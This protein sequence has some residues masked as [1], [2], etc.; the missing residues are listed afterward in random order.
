VIAEG[1]IF[2][3]ERRGY[4]QAGPFVPE[5]L[6]EEPE[7]IKNLHKEFVRAGSDVIVA[8]TYYVNTPKLEVIGKDKTLSLEAVNKAAIRLAKEVRSE[9]GNEHCLVCGDISNST[10]Y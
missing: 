10:T 2:E 4:V 9:K 6:W 8:C 1:Y 7:V 3:L 5:C